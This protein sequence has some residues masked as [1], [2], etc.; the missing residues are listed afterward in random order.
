MPCE[1]TS[2]R[3]NRESQVVLGLIFGDEPR[4]RGMIFGWDLELARQKTLFFVKP[5]PFRQH[6]GRVIST[7]DTEFRLRE[8]EARKRSASYVLG[9]A[10]SL[11]SGVELAHNLQSRKLH[12]SAVL[13]DSDLSEVRELCLNTLEKWETAY[14]DDVL[15]CLHEIAVEDL[16]A[17]KGD[18]LFAGWAKD[19]QATRGKDPYGSCR[20]FLSCFASLYHTDMYYPSLFMAREEGKTKTQFFNDYGLQAASCRK[21][22]SLGGTTNP[23]IAIL[24]EDDLDGKDNIWGQETADFISRFP[25]KWKAV[26]GLITREQVRLGR[27]DDWAATR[28]TEWVVLDAMLGL[29]S[30]FLLRGLGRVA[31]QLRPDWHDNEE[32]LVYAGAEIYT[33]L[34]AK[35][36]EFDDILLDGAEEPYPSISASRVGKPNNHF[37]IACTGQAALNVIKA[38]NAGFHPGFPGVLKERM[39]TNVTLSYDVPQMVAASVA[40]EKGIRE[41]EKRTGEHVDD[42]DGGS[43]VTSMMGRFNDSIRRYR[44][45]SLLSVLPRTSI[46]RGQVNPAAIKTLQ[47]PVINNEGFI[48]LMRQAGI[49]FDPVIEEDAIDHAATLLT[50]RTILLLTNKYGYKKT[51]IL[52]ASKRQFHQNTEL[53]G[54]PFSTDF[55][56]IQRMTIALSEGG[57][58]NIERWETFRDGMNPDGS[59]VAGSIWARR[60]EILSRMWPDWAKAYEVGGVPPDDYLKTIYV[61]PTLD[62]FTT[63]WNENIARA[64]AWRENA[65][66]ASG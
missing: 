23:V 4:T 2:S 16:A 65:L 12:G 19:W 35:V 63:F 47:D 8:A 21:I 32:K 52:T 50:K 29:R 26:R 48:A 15:T 37:K 20:E 61:K 53:L 42:G 10:D 62:Q 56:N 25:N 31:F 33:A 38:F 3:V 6:L 46:L 66:S 18:N 7:L 30:V 49:D 55:G 24:G 36:R 9:I 17:N 28:F 22:G 14:P 45:E 58:L 64:A 13:P 44:V 54:V 11:N 34:G 43:V 41:Y 27:P 57:Q 51:R 40:I 59:P 1:N 5:G 39:F 60:H